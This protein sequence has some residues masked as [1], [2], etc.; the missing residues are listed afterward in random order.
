MMLD[1]ELKKKDP[2][3]GHFYKIESDLCRPISGEQIDSEAIESVKSYL[4]D[5]HIQLPLNP[6]EINYNASADSHSYFAWDHE[7]TLASNPDSVPVAG[8]LHEMAHA[9][10]GALGIGPFIESHG[11]FFCRVLGYMWSDYTTNPSSEFFGRCRE[12]NLTVA[13]KLPNLNPNPWAVVVEGGK[14]YAVRPA[15]RAIEMGFNV[16]KTFNLNV[17]E[18]HPM[19]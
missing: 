5:N 15:H 18:N 6:P 14:E 19:G 3:R 1:Y 9:K 16:K 10:L 11:G 7:I 13:R 2:Q 12:N 8:L 4:W 17:K